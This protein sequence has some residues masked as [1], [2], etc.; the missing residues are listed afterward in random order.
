MSLASDL[1]MAIHPIIP[2]KI[3]CTERADSELSK[4]TFGLTVTLPSQKLHPAK[5]GG[6]SLKFAIFSEMMTS[7]IC[8]MT[9]HMATNIDI[10]ST[11]LGP[12]PMPHFVWFGQIWS[13]LWPENL[14]N[15]QNL[16]K[17]GVVT[18]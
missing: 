11:T 17:K 12:T 3:I 14:Q 8:R 13:K 10:L 1:N 4:Y 6:K 2:L 9:S 5:V 16:P 18:P 7:Q 15:C